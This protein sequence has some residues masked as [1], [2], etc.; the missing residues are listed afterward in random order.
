MAEYKVR[1]TLTEIYSTWVEAED[2]DA[3][4]RL[5]LEQLN[6]GKLEDCLEFVETEI[7]DVDE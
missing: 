3:A 2:E 7:D 1:I 4:R 6:Q 5:A